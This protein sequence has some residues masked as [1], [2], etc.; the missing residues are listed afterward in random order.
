MANKAA[1]KAANKTQKTGASVTQFLNGIEDPQRRAD[2]KAIAKM[3]REATGEKPAM[4][5]PS[6]VGYGSYDYRSASGREGRWFIAG[7]SPRK[8][9]LSV[10]IMAGFSGYEALLARLGQHKTG[11]SCLYIKRLA[12]V[13]R[14][15]LRRLID[16]SV[17]E[18]R[19][20]YG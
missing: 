17:A 4:W 10:Y 6:M 18:M 12:D 1:N 2:A 9:A 14:E 8:Q 16:E 15:V 13:D 11:K 19:R 3:M 20:R 7:F 5:G